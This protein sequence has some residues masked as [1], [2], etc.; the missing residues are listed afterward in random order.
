MAYRDAIS[1]SLQRVLYRDHLRFYRLST[2]PLHRSSTLRGIQSRTRRCSLSLFIF[3]LS[4]NCCLLLVFHSRTRKSNPFHYNPFQFVIFPIFLPV[5]F[6]LAVPSL[7]LSSSHSSFIFY[8]FSSIS[9]LS[10]AIYKK[11]LN[12]RKKIST[13]FAVLH[14]VFIVKCK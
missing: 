10:L 4:Q 8:S 3:P 14:F 13:L 9:N 6:V 12:S 7:S 5:P 11:K 1:D 2:P